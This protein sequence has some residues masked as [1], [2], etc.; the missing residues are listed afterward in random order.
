MLIPKI[1]KYPPKMETCYLL[2]V[3]WVSSFK[4]SAQTGNL[5]CPSCSLNMKY[6]M[7]TGLDTVVGYACKGCLQN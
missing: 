1:W 2:L 3:E 5:Q 7:S 6:F 4:Y